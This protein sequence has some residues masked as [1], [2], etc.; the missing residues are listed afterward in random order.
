MS[1]LYGTLNTNKL[2][3]ASR[4]VTRKGCEYSI[5]RGSYPFGYGIELHC[6]EGDHHMVVKRDTLFPKGVEYTTIPLHELSAICSDMDGN[7]CLTD[8]VSVW[9]ETA[10]WN[11]FYFVTVQVTE[12]IQCGE[13]TE[14]MHHQCT[15]CAGNL[16]E[17]TPSM[18][19]MSIQEVCKLMEARDHV[20]AC[21]ATGLCPCMGNGPGHEDSDLPL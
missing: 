2:E 21:G 15:Q 18:E 10:T 19:H 17:Y 12:C 5:S 20:C 13:R 4:T 14:H 7:G 16:R 8:W 1:N 9:M 3:Q 11:S 6:W